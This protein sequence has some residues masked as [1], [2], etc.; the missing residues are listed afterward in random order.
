MALCALLLA[1][2]ELEYEQPVISLYSGAIG[3]SKQV[4]QFS[5]L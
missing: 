5:I 4:F 3:L 1:V 2:P